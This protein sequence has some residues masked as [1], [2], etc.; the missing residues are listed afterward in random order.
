MK[1]VSTGFLLHSEQQRP[2]GTQ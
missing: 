2:M 1:A